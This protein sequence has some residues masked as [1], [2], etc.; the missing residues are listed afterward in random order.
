MLT[1]DGPLILVLVAVALGASLGATFR[2]AIS[3]WL[4]PLSSLPFGTLFVN[5]AGAWLIGV[6]VAFFAE[7]PTIS[8]FWRLFLVTGFLGSLTTFSTFSVE[9][10]TL[11]LNGQYGLALIHIVS[12]V[13]GSILMT[14]VGIATFRLIF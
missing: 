14:L 13:V 10:V 8:A 9:N 3:Y 7:T 4:N 12:H 11:L 2:W 5:L 6:L 1:K